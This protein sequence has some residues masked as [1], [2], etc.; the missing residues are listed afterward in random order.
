[1]TSILTATTSRA[2]CVCDN[3]H[4]TTSRY[5]AAAKRLTFLLVCPTCRAEKVVDALEY[6]P[7]FIP[8]ARNA[9]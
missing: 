9:R 5:D 6:E 8:H 4:E 3:L 7:N 2:R 1:M